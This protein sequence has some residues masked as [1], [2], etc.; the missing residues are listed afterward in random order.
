MNESLQRPRLIRKFNPGTFQSDEELVD[1]FVVRN[2][3]LGIVLDVLRGNIESSSCQHVLI[4][5]PRGRG[6]TML[7][8]RVAAELRTDDALS[9]RLLPVRFME[10]SQEI[11]SVGDFWLEALFYL[12]RE[13][14]VRDSAVSQELRDVHA[15]LAADW[16]G[17]ELE[18][19]ARAAVLQTADR[20][21]KQLV[22]MV[23][24]LQSLCRD[25]DG[26]FAWKLRKALQS[27]PQIIL[28]ATA[29]SRFKELDDAGHAF[30]ELFRTVRLE[31]LDTGECR[32]LWQMV[33]GDEVTERGIRPLQI[34]TGGNPRLLIIIGEFAQ[35][36][37]LR[38][39]M[40]ELVKLV[41]E[42]T[43]YFRGHLEV[44][45]KTERRVYLAVIDL[46]R[47]S[48]TGEIA[49]RARMDV[50]AVSALLG[51]LVERG[52]AIVEGSGK[53][54]MYAAA[55]RLYSIYYKLRRERDEAAV[56]R[57][58]I[59][60]MAAFYSVD[61]LGEMSG[62]LS[63][64]AAQ[65]PAIRKG[66]EQAIAESPRI[67]RIFDSGAPLP[68][69]RLSDRFAESGGGHVQRIL[70]ALTAAAQEGKSDKVI[71]I[72]DRFLAS[73]GLDSTQAPDDLT[74]S[75][76]LLKAFAHERRGEAKMA[77]DACHR[78]IEFAEDSKEFNLQLP[79]AIAL[80]CQGNIQGKLGQSRCAIASCDDAI[81]RFGDSDDSEL[82]VHAAMAFVNKAFVLEQL[83]D[84]DAAIATADETAERFGDNDTREVQASVASALGLKH[85]AL[86]QLGRVESAIASLDDLVERYGNSNAPELQKQ[87]AMALVAKGHALSELGETR[88]EIATLDDVV[89]QFESCDSP[90]IQ[91]Y[92]ASAMIAKGIALQRL[93]EIRAA[94]TT[95]DDVADC[96]ASSD[97]PELRMRSAMALVNKGAALTDLGDMQTAIATFD[98]VL[99]RIEGSDLPEIQEGI[100][101]TLVNKGIAH[102]QFSQHELAIST[103]DEAIERFEGKD[104]P[105]LQ[106]AVARALSRRGLAQNHLRD[107]QAAIDTWREMLGRFGN[108]GAPELQAQIVEA[109]ANMAATQVAIGHM[110]DALHTCNELEQRLDSLSSDNKIL[111]W[112]WV[113]WSRTKALL[114]QGNDRAAMAEFRFMCAAFVSDHDFMLHQMLDCVCELVAAGIIERDLVEVLTGN[115]E[116]ADA[117]QPL[118]VA[119]RQRGGEV[120]RAPSEILEVAADIRARID[121]RVATDSSARVAAPA[122]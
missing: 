17:R 85:E 13:Q 92:V 24:N 37:S 26:D 105:E 8:A 22:L 70:N 67:A 23:E 72:A 41:D 7:L 50:R 111:F 102:D 49:T 83:G 53:K 57:N 62:K 68:S 99:E 4:V 77:I 42:H 100:A 106:E 56:V 48:T 113:K 12:A 74:A 28:L 6:K 91:S 38:Q 75:V 58:L 120:I 81:G 109:L 65:W 61:E 90:G 101:R 59:H 44:F 34:L 5:A 11:F 97:Q 88:S 35:H 86:K 79:I 119:L 114:A 47:P 14:V 25:G 60:F 46:W 82:Q 52:V 29:T 9:E 30:F 33:S 20:L 2:R 96:Y 43:E 84:Y 115:Q 31:P 94:I 112:W 45:A 10:E 80:V 95:Y 118:I 78:V 103:F 36:R 15:A 63:A 18:A 73:C 71:E 40:E 98:D 51:R 87:V 64:K 76:I 1:Q 55:E 122:T 66:I 32:R 3:E 39:L 93:G 27:E 89:V 54:R 108:T 19:R 107:S 110:E 121:E 16:H 69:V 117:L 104:I 116:K 21:G